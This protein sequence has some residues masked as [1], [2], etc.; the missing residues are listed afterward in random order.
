MEFNWK[1]AFFYIF[2]VAILWRLLLFLYTQ[3][4]YVYNMFDCFRSWNK[5]NYN[6]GECNYKVF[7]LYI[8]HP[9]HH[10]SRKRQT[11]ANRIDIVKCWL[12]QFKIQCSIHLFST[13]ILSK[14]QLDDF[15][16]RNESLLFSL[17]YLR[18]DKST[19]SVRFIDFE[20]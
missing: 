20:L 1:F 13:N 16:Y 5:I 18:I 3:Y 15:L 14:L 19:K 6:F 10:L 12:V 7:N 11:N 4:V 8:Y 9:Y 2:F 17:P